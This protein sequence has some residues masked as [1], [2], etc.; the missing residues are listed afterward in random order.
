[1]KRLNSKAGAVP[2]KRGR[3]GRIKRRCLA[4]RLQKK[5]SSRTEDSRKKELP[6]VYLS[7]KNPLRATYYYMKGS[8][9]RC[10]IGSDRSAHGMRWNY[11]MR[12]GRRMLRIPLAFASLPGVTSGIMRSIKTDG[13]RT[14]SQDILEGRKCSSR[15][16]R[17]ASERS[18]TSPKLFW[19]G[20]Q[21][22][23]NKDNNPRPPSQKAQRIKPEQKVSASVPTA[24]ATEAGKTRTKVVHLAIP[25]MERAKSKGES[26]PPNVSRKHIR[27]AGR[28]A[29]NRQ[30]R[31]VVH[32]VRT[33]APAS[34]CPRSRSRAARQSARA[35][36]AKAVSKR[37][38]SAKAKAVSGPRSRPV[39][40]RSGTP[41]SNNP[42]VRGIVSRQEKAQ[43]HIGYISSGA[44]K[45]GVQL[46]VAQAD[47]NPTK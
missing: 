37:A 46:K 38:R 15:K 27:P 13:R 35:E 8:R 20:A 29:Q 39:S 43:R 9:G 19:G 4:E 25:R 5:L 3:A 34:P 28:K 24:R 2:L 10:K 7:F 18:R 47:A 45:K 33:V 44:K 32:A 40:A 23:G 1:M 14:A 41:A 12:R 42:K 31:Q 6:K 11:Y 17:T 26:Q 36:K 22:T 16:E 21:K 30:E